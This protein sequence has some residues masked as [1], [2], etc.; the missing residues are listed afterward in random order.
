MNAMKYAP[1]GARLIL[2]LNF[3]VFGLNGFFQFIPMPPMEGPPADFMGALGATGY[4]FPLLKTTETT[5]GLALLSGF[6]VPLALVVLAPITINILAFHTF[7][8]PD[9]LPL[10]IAI[11]TL[12]IFLASSNRGSYRSV[13]AMRA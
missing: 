9:G 12:Q 7:L 3:T 1:L 13:L 4:F 10:A 8:A 5:V 2:G 6:F 11:V